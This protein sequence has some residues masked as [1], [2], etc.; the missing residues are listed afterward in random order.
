MK[1]G[2]ICAAVL[3]LAGCAS[4]PDN[5]Y[6]ILEAVPPSAPSTPSAPLRLNGFHLPPLYDRPQIVER[7]GPQSVA[8]LEY[9]R[10][11]E[12]LDRMGARVLRRDLE[13]RGVAS[14]G[15]GAGLVVTVDEFMAD[16]SGSVTF[17]GGW[18]IGEC[19]DR[20]FA[21]TERSDGTDSARIASAMSRLLGRLADELALQSERCA[22]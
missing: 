5:R 19:R 21:M 4:S 8:F 17:N 9:D 2:F 12:P 6:Y 10:W 15:A 7:S 18:R 16:R 20:H 11:A 1:R 3:I 14:Q 22:S 13:L